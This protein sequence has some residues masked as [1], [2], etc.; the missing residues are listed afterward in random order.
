MHC[1]PFLSSVYTKS[2]LSTGQ[3]RMSNSSFGSGSFVDFDF[4][5]FNCSLDVAI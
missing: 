3:A 2:A 4:G 5:M 1:S